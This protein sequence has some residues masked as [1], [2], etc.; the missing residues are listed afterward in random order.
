MGL[1]A[2]D[3]VSAA[4][5]NCDSTSSKLEEAVGEEAQMPLEKEEKD[6]DRSI[7]NIVEVQVC[8][9]FGKISFVR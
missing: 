7:S 5:A 8:I 2:S 9:F 3:A 4:T 1:V 6:L